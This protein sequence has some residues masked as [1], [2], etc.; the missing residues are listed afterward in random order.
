MPFLKIGF[1]NNGTIIFVLIQKSLILLLQNQQFL[2]RKM[3]N[4]LLYLVLLWVLLPNTG[5]AKRLSC[6]NKGNQ[7]R[8]KSGHQPIS[9]LTCGI[10]ELSDLSSQTST[11]RKSHQGLAAISTNGWTW[12]CVLTGNLR[13]DWWIMV[14]IVS[15]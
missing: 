3:L 15:L 4:N 9:S 10:D 6:I 14:F 8:K 1:Q 12:H 11:L 2:S 13:K 7:K 5:A